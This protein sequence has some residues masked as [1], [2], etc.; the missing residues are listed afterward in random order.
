VSC[1][2][3]YCFDNGTFYRCS[4]TREV[5]TQDCI[6]NECKELELARLNKGVK[7][8]PSVNGHDE[9]LHYLERNSVE[10]MIGQY[11][12]EEIA[13]SAGFYERRGWVMYVDGDE[14]NPK[15]RPHKKFR[16]LHIYG[17]YNYIHGYRSGMRW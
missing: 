2:C 9:D 8:N 7:F 14:V 5:I 4:L 3:E 1:D 11:T 6:L 16:E 15:V 12:F 17:S 10:V 13:N